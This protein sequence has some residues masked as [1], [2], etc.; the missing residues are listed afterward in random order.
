MEDFYHSIFRS[1]SFANALNKI[2]K[3]KRH[4]QKN[5]EHSQAVY[6]YTVAQT[7]R[8]LRRLSLALLLWGIS[9]YTMSVMGVVASIR[10]PLTAPLPDLGF[11]LFSSIPVPEILTNLIM[12]FIVSPEK[13]LHLLT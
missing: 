7:K 2:E 8:E 12:S 6:T 4:I 11:D 9:G 5:I 13:C 10:A 1:P 3:T